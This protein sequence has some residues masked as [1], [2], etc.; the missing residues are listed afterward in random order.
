[1]HG[2]YEVWRMIIET[3]RDLHVARARRNPHQAP[4]PDISVTATLRRWLRRLRGDRPL[5]AAAFP[6]PHRRL[7]CPL[8]VRYHPA[9]C[10]CVLSERRRRYGSCTAGLRFR[11]RRLTRCE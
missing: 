7:R 2:H 1:M 8:P 6:E 10:E 4:G 3:E 5:A 11:S 9:G